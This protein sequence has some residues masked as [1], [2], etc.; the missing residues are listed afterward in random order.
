MS[1]EFSFLSRTEFDQLV[2]DFLKGQKRAQQRKSII[3][4]ED[5][6]L[7]IK[8]LKDPEDVSNGNAK[9]RYWAKNNFYLRDIGTLQNPI[10][11]IMAQNKSKKR[12]DRVV[13]PFQSLYEIIGKVHGSMQKH[14]G[15]K[16][17][18]A[19]VWL[20]SVYYYYFHSI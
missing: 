10:V 4:Q 9:D 16:K 12:Q 3:T 6:D 17:T 14:A 2:R 8:I 7:L 13:C 20:K 15:A 18:Y 11:Q 5:Y 19:T 1:E